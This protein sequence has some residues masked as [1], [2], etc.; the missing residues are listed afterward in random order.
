GGTTNIDLSAATGEL[1]VKWYDPRNGGALQNGTVTTVTGGA[2]RGIGQAPNNISQDWVVLVRKPLVIQQ[3]PLGGV[4]RVIGH[5]S[6]LQFEDYDEG[7]E[8]KAFHDS[9]GISQGDPVRQT[10]VDGGSGVGAVGEVIA[11]TVNG[12]WLEYT[13]SPV[14]GTYYA[15]LRYSSGHA[16]PGTLKMLLG[17]GPEGTNFTTLATFDPVNTGGFNEWAWL[18]IPGITLP[19]GS[20][21]VL[22]F[23]IVGG[24]FNLDFIEFTTN[25]PVNTPP[26]VN[27]DGFRQVTTGTTGNENVFQ[28]QGGYV[29]MEV[30]SHGA[31]GGWAFRNT[32]PT[33]ATGSGFYEWQGP[34]LFGQN[35]AGTQGLMEYKF[36]VDSAGTYQMRI[37]NHRTISTGEADDTENDV[38]AKM[39][40][41]PWYKVFSGTKNQW[42]WNSNFDWHEL[43]GTQPPA[44]YDLTAGEHTFYLS[45][46]SEFFRID[47]IAIFQSNKQSI[48]Q[49]I[50]TPESPQSGDEPEVVGYQINAT[51]TD[52][53]RLF[54][55]PQ[56]TWS[57]VSGPG[58]VVFDNPNAE[59]VVATFSID[60]LYTLKLTAYDGQHT[61]SDTIT[62]YAG[63]QINTSP[64]VDA[65][66]NITVPWPGMTADLDGTVGD[67]GLPIPPGSVSVQWS[68]VSGPGS[69]TFANAN[70]A[71]TQATFSMTGQYVL[72]LSASDGDLSAYDDVTV[73]VQG[74]TSTQI[75]TS[76]NDAYLEDS[77]RIN[78]EYLKIEDATRQRTSYVKFNLTGLAGRVV[79]NASLTFTVA[80][81]AGSGTLQLWLGSHNSWTEGNLSTSNAPTKQTLLDTVTG[82]QCAWK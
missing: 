66:S 62:L 45:G 29:I 9:D 19:G 17:D 51:V 70:L 82:T 13:I 40:N 37:R 1:E 28:D 52:D 2:S 77:T 50:N 34:N 63:T 61:V 11:W 58:N 43:N 73:D 67:D 5:G 41:G 44:S 75:F 6:L 56:L 55:P 3:G 80:G 57:K 22:R 54:Y 48:A 64:T 79:E 15:S 31:T 26:T 72:R 46:R 65:G 25:A 27:I 35:K 4:P 12:E 21:K 14:A 74:N 20:E 71:D 78:N 23:E 33:G 59:D 18:T 68:K 8:G 76:M 30:E 10:G 36:Q 39:D 16:N 42:N 53:A 38:W 49:N 24:N 32:D 81:D 69:V 7:G 47:R 60:G